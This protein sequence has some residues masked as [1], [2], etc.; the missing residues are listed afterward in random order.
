MTSPRPSHPDS[1]RTLPATLTPDGSLLTYYLITSLAL[2]P[3]FLF[4]F[5]PLYF[6]YRSLRYEVDDEGITA[7][8]GVL[9][10]KEISLNYARIQD[11]HLTSNLLERWLGIAKIQIQTASGNAGAELTIQ[12]L[13]EYDAIRDF[14]YSK[15]RGAKD[16][17]LPR[18]DAPGQPAAA[19]PPAAVDELTATLRGIAAD[20][21]A[22]RQAL[23]AGA[24]PGAEPGVGGGGHA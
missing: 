9:F 4:S 2:G 8:W 12:G 18:A 24:Q 22:L 14:L 10:R 16:H 23:P 3:F 11:I 20:V 6:R 21:R 13:P 7:R 17:R 5:L 15:M 19:L 1:L